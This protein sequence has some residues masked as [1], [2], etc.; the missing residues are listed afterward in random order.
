MKVVNCGMYPEHFVYLS[1]DFDRVILIDA[2]QMGLPA[3]ETRIIPKNMLAKSAISTHN[4]PLYLL[5]D[6][7]EKD[8]KEVI[9][10]G[11]QPAKLEGELSEKVKRAG[12][13]LAMLI[14]EGRLKEIKRL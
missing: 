2:V 1:R 10:I 11:I 13:K 5:I 14:S 6:F 8:G 7:L 4:L 9:F 12:E 3:G